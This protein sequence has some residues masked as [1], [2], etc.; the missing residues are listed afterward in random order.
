MTKNGKNIFPEEVELYLSKCDYIK[1]V[2][3]WGVMTRK[4]GHRRP[5]RDLPDREAIEER[6]GKISEEE[7]RRI[8]KKEIDEIN[9]HMPLYKRVK[10]F[11]IEKRNLKKRPRK[12]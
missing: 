6:F 2:V 7:L 11:E 1:E 8:L 9:E 10:R 12:K 3:V 5:G 4:R